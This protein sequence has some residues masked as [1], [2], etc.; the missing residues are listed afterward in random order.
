VRSKVVDLGCGSGAA[1]WAALAWLASVKDAEATESDSPLDVW[2]VDR[3]SR[4]LALA[5]ELS[6]RVLDA[7]PNLK[8][9]IHI[10]RADLRERPRVPND[11]L[12]LLSHVL[13]EHRH[14]LNALLFSMVRERPEEEVLIV[15]RHDD[16]V[17]ADI[18]HAAVRLRWYRGG[19][20]ISVDR[21]VQTL[22]PPPSHKAAGLRTRWM[23]LSHLEH[24]PV[25]RLVARYFEIWRDQDVDRLSEVFAQDAKYTYE[26]FAESLVGLEAIAEYWRREVLPQVRLTITLDSLTLTASQGI[27]EWTA[28]FERGRQRVEMRGMMVLLVNSSAERVI[29]L[30]EYYRTAKHR[31]P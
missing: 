27:V 22:V 13:T 4:S 15:E 30:R 10:R 23:L 2:L 29:E 21:R 17:W 26:P 16:D 7:L 6:I 25:A 8:P 12:I 14:D 18:D 19:E 3:S 11:S 5:D 24:P 9:T 31:V 20:Q 1:A 28:S